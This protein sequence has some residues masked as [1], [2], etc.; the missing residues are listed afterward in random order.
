MKVHWTVLVKVSSAALLSFLEQDDTMEQVNTKSGFHLPTRL[1]E[2]PPTGRGFL[3]GGLSPRDHCLFG[4][5][6][7]LESPVIC[8]GP[9]GADA[10]GLDDAL[11]I[12][13]A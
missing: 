5:F 11:L 13:Y 12:T 10:R 8:D 1:T 6:L 4:R 7:G 3:L 9:V 2:S